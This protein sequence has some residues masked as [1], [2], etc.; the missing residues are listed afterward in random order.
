MRVAY[1]SDIH[2]DF[3]VK[4]TNPERSDLSK[5]VASLISRI[6]PEP[7]DVLIIAGDLG[8]YFNQN[9]EFLKQMLAFYPDIVLVTGNHDM[10]LVSRSTQYKYSFESMNRIKEMKK[11]C[12]STP[13]L[14][15][16]DGNTVELGGVVFGG[17]G[18]GWNDSYFHRVNGYKPSRKEITDRYK[19]V[20][21]DSRFILSKKY[22]PVSPSDDLYDFPGITPF[23]PS[24]YFHQE[25]KKLNSI[26]NVDVMITH[27]GPVIPPTLREEYARSSDTTFFYFGGEDDVKRISPAIWVFGHTH[28]M[29]DFMH[30]KTRMLCNPLGYPGEHQSERVMYFDIS[31]DKTEEKTYP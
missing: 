16:L 7:A 3:W 29:Y 22:A 1:I 17:V 18:M 13:G 24:Q 26:K 21:N 9:A 14:H 19:R 11:F 15:Y 30:N 5:Q 2:V 25:L 10:Y 8:H 6:N 31:N 20:M 28:D 4:Q 23:D 27:Y 12:S